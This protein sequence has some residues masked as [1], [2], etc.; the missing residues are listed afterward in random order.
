MPNMMS[1][2][3]FAAIQKPDQGGFD[4]A[5]AAHIWRIVVS[6][7]EK[8]LNPPEGKDRNYS[9]GSW[10]M[11]K[12]D[13]KPYLDLMWSCGRTSYM[14]GNVIAGGGCHSGVQSFQP[15]E[16]QFTNQKM[17]YDRVVA[18]QNPVKS[19]VKGVKGALETID[20][21]LAK[22]RLNA[23]EKAQVQLMAN[24]ALEIVTAIEK[25]GSWGVHGPSFTMKKVNEAKLLTDGAVSALAGK[26]KL[27]A[28]NK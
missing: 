12:K 14:D 8:T 19:G 13:G 26:S 11:T 28:A 10:R 9:D 25:D 3:N 15:K 18:W 7:D 6:P 16:L 5:R 22:S 21:G 2:E 27:M 1:C 17:I 20:K 4:T 23:A 24:Q